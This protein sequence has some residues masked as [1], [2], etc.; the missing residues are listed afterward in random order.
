MALSLFFALVVAVTSDASSR[1]D[2]RPVVLDP[3]YQHDRF[4][5]LPKDRFLQFRAYS[6]S[7]DSSD[8]DNG[9][10]VSD[11]L[12]VPEWVSYELCESPDPMPD[13]S[14][15][16]SPWITDEELTEAGLVPDDDSYKHSG[17]SR[18]HMC[19]RSH[20]QRMGTD[21]DFNTH[22]VFNACPQLQSMN[23]GVWKGLENKTGEWADEFGAVW[24]I[25]GPVIYGQTPSATIG[26]LGEVPVA[27]PDAFFKI[28]VKEA[29]ADGDFDVL[30]FLI[31]MEGLG[32]F[33]SSNHDLMPY[34]TSVDVLE[35]LT[36]LDFLTVLDNAE[37]VQVEKTVAIELW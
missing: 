13:A 25:C 32:D 4:Q 1:T 14:G 19:M 20:A 33:N 7:F 35:A 9:D 10:G 28:V 3:S 5:T 31:P 22:T 21:A 29:D 16:V 6:T 17:F 15:G 36:G 27:V 26:D 34:L 23:N 2:F 24:I 30:A 8:D 12:G 11:L 37:E 18:G